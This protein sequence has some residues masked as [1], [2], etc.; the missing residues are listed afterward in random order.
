MLET[1]DI[2]RPKAPIDHQAAVSVQLLKHSVT[3][4]VVV[5]SSILNRLFA[6]DPTLFLHGCYHEVAVSAVPV[7][8][9]RLRDVRLPQCVEA[10]RVQG[11][12]A[13]RAHGQMVGVEFGCC[14]PGEARHQHLVCAVLVDSAADLARNV[15]GLARARRTEDPVF[16]RDR[17]I[18]PAD[19]VEICRAAINCHGGC[20]RGIGRNAYRDHTQRLAISIASDRQALCESEIPSL[21]PLKASL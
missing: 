12:D 15:G 11:A 8:Y 7:G 16:A 13:V 21:P 5:L 17:M 4:L 2:G 1:T 14:S 3:E 18:L 20:P 19:V 10:N 6:V 9:V